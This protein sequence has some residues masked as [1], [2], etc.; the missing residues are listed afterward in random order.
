MFDLKEELAKIAS[1]N[2]QITKEILKNVI[3]QKPASIKKPAAENKLMENMR[4]LAGIIV[5]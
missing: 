5:R 1:T 3:N 2:K 4:L